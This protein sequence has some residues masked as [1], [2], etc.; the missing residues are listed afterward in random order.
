MK[1]G[2]AVKSAWR[3]SGARDMGVSLKSY[4]R[5]TA[6]ALEAAGP[7]SHLLPILIAWLDAK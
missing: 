2:H 5:K 3:K 7:P 6:R 1:C 4:A